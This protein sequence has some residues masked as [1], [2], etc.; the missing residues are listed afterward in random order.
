MNWAVLAWNQHKSASISIVAFLELPCLLETIGQQPSVPSQWRLY[1]FQWLSTQVKL[2]TTFGETVDFS[3]YIKY[4]N[5][6][7]NGRQQS[8]EQLRL[9]SP[10]SVECIAGSR[11]TLVTSVTLP[12]FQFKKF[13]DKIA[14]MQEFT[15]RRLAFVSGG[16]STIPS[17]F[18]QRN[19]KGFSA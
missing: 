11:Y 3:C 19:V 7:Q 6:I 18:P 5:K 17:I 12:I 10:R 2:R 15:Y 9:Q 13:L 8:P 1:S 14:I 4:P 16:N